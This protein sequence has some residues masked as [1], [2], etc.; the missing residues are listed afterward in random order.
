MAKQCNDDDD[1]DDAVIRPVRKHK[2]AAVVSDDD[3]DDD[4][5]MMIDI[6]S[7]SMVTTP[8]AKHGISD[9]CEDM[10]VLVKFQRDIIE[11]HDSTKDAYFI[12]RGAKVTGDHA[13]AEARCLEKEFGVGKPQKIEKCWKWYSLENIFVSPVIPCRLTNRPME[14]TFEY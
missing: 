14:W 12:G 10:W 2:K 5:S 6:H 13:G 9:L 1:D 4:E 11:A 8:L 7:E 3:T